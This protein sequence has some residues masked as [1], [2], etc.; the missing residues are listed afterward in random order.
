M[1]SDEWVDEG[2][3]SKHGTLQPGYLPG[4]T[5]VHIKTGVCRELLVTDGQSIEDA[6][7]RQQWEITD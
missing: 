1:W 7:D 5:M 4:H 2:I 3:S 6:I